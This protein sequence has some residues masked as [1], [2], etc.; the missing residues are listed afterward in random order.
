M[1]VTSR[2]TETVNTSSASETRTLSSF[3][4][5]MLAVLRIAFGLTF[6]WAF[7]DKLLGL[8]FSTKPEAAWIVGGNPTYGF[9]AKGSSGPFQG[10]YNSIAGQ[11]WTNWLFMIALLAIG[12]ALVLGI[13]L[14]ITA[15]A[16]GIL[17]LMMWSVALPPTTNPV[18]DDHIL[19]AL[20]L[21]VFA[22]TAAGLTWGLSKQWR[23][24][25]FVAKNHW[26]W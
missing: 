19:G 25:T 4:A 23:S 24:V 18:I 12:L 3:G 1:S 8:G 15:V 2:P 5:K 20:S 22:A 6:L 7:F 10:F 14:R 26:L 9:L 17:Y 13:G 16:G 21:I 11:T